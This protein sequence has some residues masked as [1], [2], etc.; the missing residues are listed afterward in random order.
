MKEIA[1]TKYY[2]EPEVMELFGFKS[3]VSLWRR[4]RSGKLNAYRFGNQNYY[5]E[6]E[7]RRYAETC[8][9]LPPFMRAA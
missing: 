7:L 3:R 1:G 9:V 5:T 8:R 6:D 2:P 4:R